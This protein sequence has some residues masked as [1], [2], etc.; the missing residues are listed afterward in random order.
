MFASPYN[1][2]MTFLVANNTFSNNF[3]YSHAQKSQSSF[4]NMSLASLAIM[5]NSNPVVFRSRAAKP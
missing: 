2:Y 3:K 1:S 4:G 5:K